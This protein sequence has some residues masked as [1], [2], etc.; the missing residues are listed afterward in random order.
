MC[1]CAR[2]RVYL[3]VHPCAC[4]KHVEGRRQHF[5]PSIMWTGRIDLRLPGLAAGTVTCRAI[6]R[7]S[8]QSVTLVLLCPP[9]QGLCS[10]AL[11]PGP[12][13][14]CACAIPLS[15][16]TSQTAVSLRPLLSFNKPVL[17]SFSNHLPAPHLQ[18]PLCWF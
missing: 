13:T 4:N 6:S 10:P 15:H 18:M 3:C 7:T 12:C 14:R 8:L 1:A 11:T 9:R 17:G 2:V 16:S 5:L